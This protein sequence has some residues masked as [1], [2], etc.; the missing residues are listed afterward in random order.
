MFTISRPL[1]N[2]TTVIYDSKIG[3]IISLPKTNF[4][5][6]RLFN[7]SE[8]ITIEKNK[9]KATPHDK[10]D[11]IKYF[12]DY[13]FIKNV[14]FHDNLKY[15]IDYINKHN[16]ESKIIDAYHSK[17]TTIE[18]QKQE[19]TIS[20][21][22]FAD[23]Y[24]STVNYL[25]KKTS[26][27][28]KFLDIDD[29]EKN[30]EILFERCKL[31]MC[32]LN[33]IEKN[34]KKSQKTNLQLHFI[35]ENP[36]NFIT[37]EYQLIP[38]DKAESICNE[39]E[40]S[41]DFKIKSKAWSYDLFLN[42]HKTYFI[43]K[44]KYNDC[45]KKFCENRNENCDN[46]IAFINSFMVTKKIEGN[47][48]IT[49][50][51]LLTKEMNMTDLMIDLY[52]GESFDVDEDKIN[53]LIN[54]FEIKTRNERNN[55]DY[56]LEI[57]QREAVI[58][59]IS[60]HCSILTGPPGSGKT[61]II[62]CFTWVLNKL[63]KENEDN[64]DN[65]EEDENSAE[66]VHKYINPENISLMA[67]TGLAFINLQKNIQDKNYNKNISGTCHRSLYHIF[68][69]ILLHKDPEC[70][71]CGEECLY[72][73][74]PKLIIIDETSMLDTSMFHDILKMCKTF[75]SRLI[76]LGDIQ[77]LPSIAAGTVLKN[78]INSG[79]FEITQLTKIKRQ[80]AGCLVNNITKMSKNG[81]IT[82]SD[83]TDS[84]MELIASEEFIVD[85]KING[86]SLKQFI[87]QNNLN[88]NTTKFIT[89]FKNTKFKFNTNEIN[90]ILQDIFNPRNSEMEFDEIPSNSKYDDKQLY[91]IKDKIV[92]T[93]NDYSDNFRANG[94]EAEI[95]DYNGETVTIK[96]SGPDDKPEEIRT[97]VL[98]EEFA[99][100]Y[101]ITIH[102]S[103]G[104]QYPNVVVLIEPETSFLEKAAV[105]TAISRSRE[106]CIII[107]NPNDFISCQKTNNTKKISLFM[108][109]SNKYEDD[110]PDFSEPTERRLY[111]EISFQNKHK[112]KENDCFYDEEKKD[113]Y[114]FDI[115]IYELL[116]LVP[117]LQKHKTFANKVFIKEN[118]G[119]FN[120]ET[121]MWY[122]Y[123]SN[124][125]LKEFM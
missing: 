42:K 98:Y 35:Y 4:A 99:L 58:K 62:K 119:D 110:L 37:E 52:N 120:I 18:K 47:N 14:I 79:F 59:G 91:R 64:E 16:S 114:T 92:R 1:K 95:L 12:K 7:A 27:R 8:I 57:E 97:S 105:Y 75:N 66:M 109:I 26:S 28:F 10:G 106:K 101:A 56:S 117:L 6:I 48:Y 33:K 102:K 113:W 90:I 72:K 41:I 3:Q 82:Q 124:E 116:K 73:N 40:L 70:C 76:L 78:I 2:G 63:F 36:F 87:I 77:Q 32:Q 46:Y 55:M 67:P 34:L 5:T 30:I 22:K 15:E 38:Y 103:Q 122:T 51:Y 118:G 45:F 88:K 23:R 65:E 104:S 125:R 9:L 69:N 17:I 24:N 86:E 111:L 60:Y 44:S 19:K 115:N 29:V 25:N 112:A 11:L 93:E 54:E 20:Y 89:P 123:K 61:E 74:E 50:N 85:D 108:R 81:I 80:N 68:E 21:L 13:Y 100:N 39:F 96:Y 53:S 43:I 83:F 94:E 31:K 71:N 49:T 121:R 84:T 107:S